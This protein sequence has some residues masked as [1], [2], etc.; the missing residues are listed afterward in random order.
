VPPGGNER[1]T[2]GGGGNDNLE[3]ALQ[4]NASIAL[5]GGGGGGQGGR[6]KRAKACVKKGLC[7]KRGK[8]VRT[9]QE[10]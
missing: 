7:R 6:G 8:K 1:G 5:W 2:G 3:V 10:D 9:I 4:E